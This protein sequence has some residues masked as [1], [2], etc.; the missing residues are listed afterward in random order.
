MN[1]I[2]YSRDIERECERNICY[3]YLLNEAKAPD[4]TT[5]ARF[6]N[7]ILTVVME[8]IFYELIKKL[9]E[10]NEIQFKNLFVDGT[11]IEANA[12]RYTFVWKKATEKFEER[13]KQKF[14]SVFIE[15][16]NR[17]EIR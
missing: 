11:N 6:K 2:Y 3:M 10:R 15:I 14:E 8:E 16:K 7:K 5:I 13:T 9:S 1:N 17:Y 12:N 4:H